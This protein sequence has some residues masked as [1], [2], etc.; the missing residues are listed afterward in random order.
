MC[1]LEFGVGRQARVSPDRD[2]LQAVA[3]KEA[4]SHWICLGKNL[5]TCVYSRYA[6]IRTQVF[7]RFHEM[8]RTAVV[9]LD[10]I[11]PKE[12]R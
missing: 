9:S 3:T 12:P 6:E 11:W 5:S 4:V 7:A 10:I 2:L 8:S 1:R